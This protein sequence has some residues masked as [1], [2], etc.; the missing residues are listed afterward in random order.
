MTRNSHVSRSKESRKAV[1]A[2]PKTSVKSKNTK[3]PEFMPNIRPVRGQKEVKVCRPRPKLLLE[4]SGA[5]GSTSKVP[6]KV[7]IRHA[8]DQAVKET[9][10][11]ES[12]SDEDE[13]DVPATPEG[14]DSLY[15]FDAYT[16]PDQGGHVLSAAVVRAV[17]Q[18]ETKQ[19][20]KLAREYEFVGL[21]DPEDLDEGYGGHDDGIRT[22]R[23]C[24]L[25]T[26][27]LSHR[28]L[29]L[30]HHLLLPF[31]TVYCFVMISW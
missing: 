20:E 23:A 18:F 10:G 27:S 26:L 16:S 7:S 22:Y 31:P 25:L 12:S 4:Y 1:A 24:E 3:V 6:V 8:I 17:D 30:L 2:P 14:L 15:S 28:S 29:I 21:I 13:F 5:A 19:T 11:V 9:R